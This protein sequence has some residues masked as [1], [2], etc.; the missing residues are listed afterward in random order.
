MFP[1][2]L[3]VLPALPLCLAAASGAHAQLVAGQIYGGSVQYN[4]VCSNGGVGFYSEPVRVIAAKNGDANYLFTNVTSGSTD[5]QGNPIPEGGI[6]LLIFTAHKNL[7]T[8][9]GAIY[10]NTYDGYSVQNGSWPQTFTN[11]TGGVVTATG[12]FNIFDSGGHIVCT[13]PTNATFIPLPKGL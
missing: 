9:Q 2:K 12:T 7:W 5:S 8:S 13:E 3:F 10:T 4:N 1:K 6:S 11:G